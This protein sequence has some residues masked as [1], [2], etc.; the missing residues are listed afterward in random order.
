MLELI[1]KSLY[2]MLPVYMANMTPVFLAKIPHVKDWNLPIDFGK[3]WAGSE[4]F[5]SHKTW[6]GFIGGILAAMIFVWIQSLL[7]GFFSSIS[8]VDYSSANILLF[9]FLLG[10]GAVAGDLAKSFF[11][12][13]IGKKP[14]ESWPFFDQLDY[15]IGAFVFVSLVYRPPLDVVITVFIMTPIL[16]VSVNLIGYFLKLKEVWW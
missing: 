2:F 1:L 11:K 9:G 6:R 14:G 13:R 3:T 16:N 15:V 4:I 10:F 5:G 7:M 12:R 8:L